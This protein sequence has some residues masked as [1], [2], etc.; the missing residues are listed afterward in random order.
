MNKKHF[1]A[2]IESG[3]E[4]TL[5]NLV[6]LSVVHE[7]QL[8]T[9]SHILKCKANF[10]ETAFLCSTELSSTCNFS[11]IIGNNLATIRELSGE[12]LKSQN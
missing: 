3:Y 7:L 11:Y 4:K 6:P 10:F 8:A 2:K 5:R 9:C 12:T 1:P